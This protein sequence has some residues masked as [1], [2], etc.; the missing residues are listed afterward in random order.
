MRT[1]TGIARRR[2][3][4][5]VLKATKGY[6]MTKGRLYRVSHEAYLHA[7]NYSFAHRKR[8]PTQI[9]RVWIDRINAAARLNDTTY[10]ELM[11]KM[12]KA[13]VRLNKKVLADIAYNN[14][15]S[16]SSLVKS[17]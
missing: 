14:P 16:F 4:N 3:H 17:L 6:R 1:K 10:S 5:K 11:D 9:R 7:G 15:E 12:H 2:R 13:D 8:R